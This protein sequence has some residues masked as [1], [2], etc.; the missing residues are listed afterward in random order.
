[1]DMC[2]LGKTDVILGILWLQAHN[3][4]INWKT[5]KIKMIRCPLL[6]GKNTKGKEAKKAKKGKEVAILEKEKVVRQAIDDKEDW[7]REKEVK[8]DHRKIEKIVPKKFLKQKK[9]FRKVESERMP[10]RKIWDHTID[11][12]ETCKP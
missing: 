2:N 1:M 4:E 11:L 8:A 3:L 6:C 5:G 10:M 12:K 7:E 9:V